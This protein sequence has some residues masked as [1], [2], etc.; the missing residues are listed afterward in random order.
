[1]KKII[2]KILPKAVGSYINFLSLWA[3]QKAF[4]LAY[5]LFSNPRKGQLQ[6]SEL[7]PILQSAQRETLQKNGH[8]FETYH[9]AGNATTVLLVHGWESNTARWEKL[10]AHL[11]KSGFSILALDAPA[12]GLSS[13]REFNIPLYASF[14]DVLVQKYQPQYIIG[15]S[16]GGA[17]ST[18]YQYYYPQHRF[19]KMVL[20]GAPSDF[21][22]ILDNFIQMLGLNASIKKQMIEYTR[23]RFSLEL[24]FFSGKYFL[25]NVE[26]P[27]LVVHDTDDS[28]VLYTEAQKLINS[29]KNAQLITTQ[30]L[31]HSLH[32][33]A[34]YQKI[35]LFLEA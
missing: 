23:Q 9:W 31:G 20:L 5:K 24:E 34:L 15:H 7:P 29:W 26:L 1:M 22:V 35:L 27:G 3:P 2:A 30:G 13:G 10:L 33:E 21:S 17:T 4:D 12:H 32:D 18:F 16:L 11:Q 6:A 14:V 8:S 19:D 25:K 28:V